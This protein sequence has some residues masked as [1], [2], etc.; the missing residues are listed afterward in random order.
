M[1]GENG[2]Q[3]Y[4]ELKMNEPYGN[5]GMTPWP[6][7]QIGVAHTMEEMAKQEI[8]IFYPEVFY[9][10]QPYVMERCNQLETYCC[11]GITPEMVNYMAENI[12]NDVCMMYPN[13]AHDSCQSAGM[14]QDFTVE[15]NQWRG[16]GN[17]GLFGN[18]IEILLLNEIFRRIGR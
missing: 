5:Q 11:M 10:V 17:S 15:A 2:M 18:L 6:Y 9:K 7:N 13:F 1:N 4:D 16:Y 8:Q 12:Y 3:N 14:K